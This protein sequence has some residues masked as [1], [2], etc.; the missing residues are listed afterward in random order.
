MTTLTLLLTLTLLIYCVKVLV[1][2]SDLEKLKLES[3][4]YDVMF[5]QVV[6]IGTIWTFTYLSLPQLHEHQ[7]M[8]IR[9]VIYVCFLCI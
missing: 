4:C 6:L 5:I 9:C 3:N 7:G 2:S 8:C 1:V